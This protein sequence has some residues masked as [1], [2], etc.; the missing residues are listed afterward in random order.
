MPNLISLIKTFYFCF[1][2]HW[3][4]FFV[5]FATLGQYKTFGNKMG[6]KIFILKWKILFS[7][8]LLCLKVA[9]KYILNLIAVSL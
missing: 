3:N 9:K 7:K 4:D 1:K 6:E 5:F 8:S 2:G